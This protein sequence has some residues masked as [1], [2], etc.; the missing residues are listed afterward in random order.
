LGALQEKTGPVAILVD[1]LQ[2]AD[3][4]STQVLGFVLRRLWA[5]RVLTV[6][7]ARSD[8]E[9]TGEQLDRLVRSA[10]GAV[11]IDMDGLRADDVGQVALG[12]LGQRLAPTVVERLHTYTKGHP[13][14][15][16]TVLAEVPVQTLRDEATERWPVPRSLRSGISKLLEGLPA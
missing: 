11:R 4:F 1:D 3:P 12:L 13:L 8:A 7:V 10:D 15:L 6:L 9:D 2:W 5:D 16:R 14:Y